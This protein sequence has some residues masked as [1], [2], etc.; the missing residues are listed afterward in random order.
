V[1]PQPPRLQWGSTEARDDLVRLPAA[2]QRVALAM[3]ARAARSL[4]LSEPCRDAPDQ[5][6]EGCGKIR[7]GV[8]E[9]PA[10]SSRRPRSLDPRWRLIVE[11]LPSEAS[12]DRLLVW[13]VAQGH[14]QPGEHT[15]DAYTLAARRRGVRLRVDAEYRKMS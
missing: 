10:G 11:Y 4:A 9:R 5:P 3:L 13:A 2:A 6:L 14:G 1:R 7:F 8:E 15:P 12:P